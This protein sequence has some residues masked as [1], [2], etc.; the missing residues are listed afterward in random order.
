[1]HQ[2]LPWRQTRKGKRVR[3][4]VQP[5]LYY[6][7]VRDKEIERERNQARTMRGPVLSLL[8]VCERDRGRERGATAYDAQSYLCHVCMCVCVRERETERESK[9]ARP[10]VQSHL[11]YV[12]VRERERERVVQVCTTGGSVLSLLCMCV[13]V[14]ACVCG[15]EREQA[16]TM[17]GPVLS[18]LRV[19]E[20][21]GG[22]QSGTSMYD[23]G[24][25]PIHVM[26]V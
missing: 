2:Q 8:R 18:L 22:K 17:R 3:C 11:L 19:C 23:V 25:G 26:C 20:R 7:C 15:R 24:F 4:G 16:C 10:G 9:C 21:E 12:C 14:C 5:Y 6:S 1:V 13:Y